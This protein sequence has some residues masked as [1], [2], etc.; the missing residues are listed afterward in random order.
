MGTVSAYK[1]GTI[2]TV[3]NQLEKIRRLPGLY[4]SQHYTLQTF[5]PLY[6]AALCT[7]HLLHGVHVRGFWRSRWSQHCRKHHF[8]FLTFAV[9]DAKP[10]SRESEWAFR[11]A[12][13][14]LVNKALQKCWAHSSRQLT[15]QCKR[16]YKFPLD[17]PPAHCTLVII[18][19]HSCHPVWETDDI[20]CSHKR[21]SKR[22]GGSM[23]SKK[24]SYCWNCIIMP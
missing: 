24:K 11:S 17:E 19:V 15:L 14:R 4:P 18:M 23:K 20:T 16:P 22:V 1:T 13:P 3:L 6:K 12:L 7:P 21:S 10:S 5:C 8:F 9:H 2:R